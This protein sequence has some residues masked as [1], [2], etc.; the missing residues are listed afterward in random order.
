MRKKATVV[1]LDPKDLTKV[2]VFCKGAPEIVFK[3][4]S[5]YFNKESKLQE[6]TE[7]K[8]TKIMTDIVDN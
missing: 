3:S 1:V 7:E 2:K 6:L 4:C 5:S 8:K